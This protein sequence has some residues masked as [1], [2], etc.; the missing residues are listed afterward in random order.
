MIDVD[1]RRARPKFDMGD[2]PLAL[3]SSRTKADAAFESETGQQPIGRARRFLRMQY[4]D[5][6]IT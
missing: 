2:G 3:F 5:I 4:Q 1:C 6:E